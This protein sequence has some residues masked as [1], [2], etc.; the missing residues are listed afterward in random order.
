M[1]EYHGAWSRDQ[2]LKINGWV[3]EDQLVAPRWDKS[4]AEILQ[5]IL[6]ELETRGSWQGKA[7]SPET[8]EGVPPQ[9]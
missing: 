3:P 4:K 2:L 8:R 5:A 9:G 1:G 7:L 6:H